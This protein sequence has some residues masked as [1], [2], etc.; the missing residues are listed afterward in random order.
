MQTLFFYLLKQASLRGSSRYT[1]PSSQLPLDIPCKELPINIHITLAISRSFLWF[2]HKLS[3]TAY[4]TRH[5]VK[6]IVTVNVIIIN[7]NFFSAYLSYL[8]YLFC[9]PH[10]SFTTASNIICVLV[11][12]KSVP[13]ALTILISFGSA[14]PSMSIC[15]VNFSSEIF[16][17][18]FYTSHQIPLLI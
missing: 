4:P 14:F 13:T 10:I 1:L 7:L 9:L 17:R 16:C 18:Y 6:R 11:A 8:L 2:L 3:H 5:A 15:L 12:P